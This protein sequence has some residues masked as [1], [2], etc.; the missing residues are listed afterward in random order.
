MSRSPVT[1]SYL[2]FFHAISTQ[3]EKSLANIHT[4][5]HPVLA[6]GILGGGGTEKILVSPVTLLAIDRNFL[7]E[8]MNYNVFLL[9]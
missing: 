8:K 4:S 9:S 6:E 2:S 1:Q 3:E 7:F 5:L